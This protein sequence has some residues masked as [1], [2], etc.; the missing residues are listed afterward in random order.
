LE[1]SESGLWP[2]GQQDLLKQMGGINYLTIFLQNLTTPIKKELT[3]E[4]A[5]L[6][7]QIHGTYNHFESCQDPLKHPILPI[8]MYLD[9]E[10]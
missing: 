4:L 3:E 8:D 9:V 6:S 1:S 5:K 7:K 2:E 10:K